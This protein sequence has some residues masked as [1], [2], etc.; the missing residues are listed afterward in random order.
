[1]ER[2]KNQ[3]NEDQLESITKDIADMQDKISK[4]KDNMSKEGLSLE[5]KQKIKNQ[6]N[7]VEN[8]IVKRKGQLEKLKDKGTSVKEDH[9]ERYKP[10]D[11]SF[12]D[13]ED[14]DPTNVSP[15]VHSI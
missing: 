5:D 2:Y 3:F 10:F 9:I 4:L 11:F 12:R 14:P 6:I 1:M 8:K 13:G 7:S 15:G